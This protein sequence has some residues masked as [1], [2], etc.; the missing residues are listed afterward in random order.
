MKQSLHILKMAL[1][2]HQG[3]NSISSISK[4]KSN[5][6]RSVPHGV[7]K[8]ELWAYKEAKSLGVGNLSTSDD[9]IFDS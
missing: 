9:L 2:I 3:T 6:T 8:R 4:R 1:N 5:G 7:T